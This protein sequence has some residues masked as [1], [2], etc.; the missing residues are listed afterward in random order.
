[1]RKVT[2]YLPLVASLSL[3]VLA[4][5]SALAATEEFTYKPASK[6]TIEANREAAKRLP[7]DDKIAFEEQARGLI[8]VFGDDKAG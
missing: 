3:W 2:I 7:Y 5:S 8:A 4:S 1:M 6:Y